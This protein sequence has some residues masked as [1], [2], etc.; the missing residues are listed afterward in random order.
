[1]KK[2]LNKIREAIEEWSKKND[3]SFVG[4]FVSFNKKGDVADNMIIGYGDKKII[5]LQLKDMTDMAKKEKDFI[6]W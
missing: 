5:K 4:S 2:E 6:N 1:M 3:V